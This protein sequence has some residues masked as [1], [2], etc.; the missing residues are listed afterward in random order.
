MSK[1]THKASQVPIE[2]I[3][4]YEQGD[5]TEEEVVSMFQDL[6]DTGLAWSLQGHY[7]RTAKHLIEA[8][9]CS[10]ANKNNS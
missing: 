7:G 8:G 3:I 9:Y 6:I 5:M 2:D 1:F 4:R 10:P